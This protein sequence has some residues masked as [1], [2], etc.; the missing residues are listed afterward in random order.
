[1]RTN[2][3][4]REGERERIERKKKRNESKAC[5]LTLFAREESVPVRNSSQPFQM[6]FKLRNSLKQSRHGLFAVQDC[7]PFVWELASQAEAGLICTKGNDLLTNCNSYPITIWLWELSFPINCF[8]NTRFTRDVHECQKGFV[9][10]RLDSTYLALFVSKAVTK[11]FE[12]LKNCWSRNKRV[13]NS[14]IKFSLGWRK[15]FLWR[16]FKY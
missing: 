9:L 16:R 8:S 13:R 5:F 11:R 1:M 3:K 2:H 15:F 4:E 12:N 14:E 7:K 6:F 10:T